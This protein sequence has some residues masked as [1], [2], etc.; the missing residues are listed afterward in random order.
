V[1]EYE[2]FP[3]IGIGKL[4]YGMTKHECNKIIGTKPIESY[5]VQWDGYTFYEYNGCIKLIF[6]E[7]MEFTAA[8]LMKKLKLFY[9]GMDLMKLKG[10]EIDY[11]TKDYQKVEKQNQN[12]RIYDIGITLEMKRINVGS[13]FVYSSSFWSDIELI[14]NKMFEK[15]AITREDLRKLL[16]KLE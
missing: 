11:F 2:Y 1:A 15:P 14:K 13:C 16:R 7:K 6:N 9:H 8:S 12:I 4:L 3:Y 5:F 10:S